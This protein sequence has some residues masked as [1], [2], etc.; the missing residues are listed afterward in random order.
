MA[1]VLRNRFLWTS[2]YLTTQHKSSQCTCTFRALIKSNKHN[3]ALRVPASAHPTLLVRPS[4][5]TGPIKLPRYCPNISTASPTAAHSRFRIPSGAAVIIVAGVAQIKSVWNTIRVGICGWSRGTVRGSKRQ[6]PGPAARMPACGTQAG[7]LSILL[8]SGCS[9]PEY[10]P[11]APTCT[12]PT[13]DAGLRPAFAFDPIG[14]PCLVYDVDHRQRGGCGIFTGAALAHWE[15]A[16]QLN[17][18]RAE[19][20]GERARFRRAGVYRH[21]P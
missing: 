19:S 11:P 17:R 3:G 7:Q 21:R 4:N 14:Q 15:T 6:A 9:F 18:L 13:W 2:A 10:S 8:W 12:I 1:L 20:P 5:S 16:R